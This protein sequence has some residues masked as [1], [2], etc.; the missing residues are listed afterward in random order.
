MTEKINVGYTVGYV[1]TVAFLFFKVG[2]SLTSFM[3][4]ANVLH[5]QL[6]EAGSLTEGGWFS[7]MSVFKRVMNALPLIGAIFGGIV[8]GTITKVGRRKATMIMGAVFAVSCLMSTILS[9]PLMFLSRLIMG[10]CLGSFVAIV[11]L[12]VGELSPQCLISPLGIIGQIMWMS[13]SCLAIFLWWF[14]PYTDHMEDAKSTQIWKFILGLPAVFS[15]IQILLFIV[16]FNHETPRYYQLINDQGK[17]EYAMRKQYLDF[18]AVAVSNSL[19]DNQSDKEQDKT[20]ELGWSDTFAPKNRKA[21]TVACL[22]AFL[23][24]MTGIG[25]VATFA[26]EVFSKEF[27]GN[28]AEHAVRFGEFCLGVIGVL[29]SIVAIYLSPKFGR[30][31]IITV[32]VVTMCFLLGVL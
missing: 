32:G 27:T 16:F 19:L 6:E 3:T 31:T 7:E 8:G 30:R 22:I 29:A 24:Q 5:I 13:G 14:V 28:D 17:Y 12:F 9:F 18:E 1:S 10:M 23:Q 20:G 26:G 11:P 4:V 15:L 21:L 2:Y 25:C